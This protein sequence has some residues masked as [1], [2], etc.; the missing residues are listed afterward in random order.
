MKV[1]LDSDPEVYRLGFGDQ[2]ALSTIRAKNLFDLREQPGVRIGVVIS[3]DTT[4]VLSRVD[5]GREAQRHR[6]D[7]RRGRPHCRGRGRR[8]R[9]GCASC[10]DGDQALE[11]DKVAQMQANLQT[12]PP[13]PFD[14]TRRMNVFSSRVQR[15]RL[16]PQHAAGPTTH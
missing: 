7:E 14:I 11:P 15:L 3:D 12:N 10:R 13:K 8:S 6:A 4:M 9:P 1:I 16:P 2:E 5:L